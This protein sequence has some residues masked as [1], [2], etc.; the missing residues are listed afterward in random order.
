MAAARLSWLARNGRSPGE[1][2]LGAAVAAQAIEAQPSFGQIKPSE[3]ARLAV[4][5]L[6]P[7]RRRGEYHR[8][9]RPASL[10]A[11]METPACSWA[12]TGCRDPAAQASRQSGGARLA[13]PRVVKALQRAHSGPAWRSDRQAG[14]CSL[15]RRQVHVSLVCD[16]GK[17]CGVRPAARPGSVPGGGESHMRVKAVA[18]TMVAP[19]IAIVSRHAA[20][21][22]T[23]CASPRAA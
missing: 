4:R 13:T 2:S 19:A 7:R 6:F 10:G 1:E 22:T 23:N 11:E 12:A 3:A 16:G 15:Q 8:R 20:A 18:A 5:Q 21:G 9:K 14:I 17:R